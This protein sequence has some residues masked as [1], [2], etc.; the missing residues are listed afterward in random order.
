MLNILKKDKEFVE[1]LLTSE[2]TITG[3]SEVNRVIAE[4]TKGQ[5]KNGKKL[6]SI[7]IKNKAENSINENSERAAINQSRGSAEE[8]LSTQKQTFYSLPKSSTFNRTFL[9]T[10]NKP[11]GVQSINLDTGESFYKDEMNQTL[12]NTSAVKEGGSPHGETA[13]KWMFNKTL[14]SFSKRSQTSL[15]NFFKRNHK[16][17][18]QI[19]GGNLLNVDYSSLFKKPNKIQNQDLREMWDEV[20]NYGPNFAHCNS[21]YNK[22]LDF[23]EKINHKEG[24]SIVNYIKTTKKFDN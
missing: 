10:G 22:N 9:K 14:N 3:N 2:D 13:K 15:A 16:V 8:M 20:N 21:C 24:I 1:Y 4:K 19:K 7:S 17:D 23:F 11:N 6:P 18:Y 12:M 5:I